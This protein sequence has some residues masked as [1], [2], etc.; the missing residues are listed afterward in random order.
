MKKRKKIAILLLSAMLMLA[1]S[2][3]LLAA[4]LPSIS[5][6]K[7]ILCYT[8][9]SSGR[10]YAYTAANLRTKTGGYI[11]CPT[12][13]C[14]ILKISGNAVQVKYPVSGGTR[15]AWFARNEFTT[16]NIVNGAA[17]KWTQKTK[18]N[19]YKHADGKD[20]YGS[21]SAGDVCYKLSESGSYMQVIYPVSDGYKM[22]W[23]AKDHKHDDAGAGST[24]R[25]I[26]DG[27]YKV[28]SAINNSYVWDIDDAS[29]ANGA[30]IQLYRDNGTNAQI[31]QFTYN[32]DGYYTIKNVNSGKA[33]DCAGGA[34]S[35]GTNIQQYTSNHSCA[36]RWKLK[37]AGNGYV[38]FICKCNGKMADVSGGVA[39]NRTNIQ[40]YQ[41]NGSTAQKF[42]LVKTA[43]LGN[44]GNH[45]G[46]VSPKPSS[47]LLFPLKGNIRTSSGAKT[48]GYRCDYK[49]SAGTPVYAPADGKVTFRQTY[50]VRYGK[51][52][53]YGNHF[54]FTSSDGKYEVKCAHLSQF[55]DVSLKYKSSLPYPCSASKYSCKT[56][57]L[58]KKRE[59][60]Q[61]DL[62][63]YAGQTG[64]A[65]GPHLHIEVKKDGKAVNPASVFE[66][67]K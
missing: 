10:V 30:N 38:S 28:A 32:Q 49:A 7:P 40:I 50:S 29:S 61:G 5:A 54:I 59:V 13:E 60:K 48:N 3:T 15:T 22:G 64:N 62:L 27:T 55:H 17:E 39:A 18:A 56:V 44:T 34:S 16:Y 21:I 6:G 33:V 53:S 37:S 31:F 51:L 41:P 35:N 57:N 11:D 42:K 9:K 45:G 1:F 26:E 58:G 8:L 4:A 24:A 20:A 36:Q 52:A 63:G 12:D 67:W 47:D 66:T 65:S 25:L 19:S 14:R 23:V 46:A 2:M 43:A